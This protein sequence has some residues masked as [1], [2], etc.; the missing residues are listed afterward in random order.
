MNALIQLPA[1]QLPAGRV[2]HFKA[3]VLMYHHL[4]QSAL[5]S[6]VPQEA[7]GNVFTSL[8]MEYRIVPVSPAGPTGI[9]PRTDVIGMTWS[10]YICILRS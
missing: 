8:L 6:C 10:T 9:L 4:Q 7:P 1:V 3:K 5:F 2:A